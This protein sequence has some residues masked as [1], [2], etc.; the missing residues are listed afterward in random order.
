MDP[1]HRRHPMEVPVKKVLILALALGCG[2]VALAYAGT[3]DAQAGGAVS[4]NSGK[5]NRKIRKTH[6]HH[7]KS[8][9]SVTN[10]GAS[11]P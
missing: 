7:K 2:V 6:H 5:T 1:A 4:T 11:Q 9:L 10:N 8:S 3:P